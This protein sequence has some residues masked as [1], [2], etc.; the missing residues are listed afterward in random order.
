MISRTIEFRGLLSFLCLIFGV[1]NALGDEMDMNTIFKELQSAALLEPFYEM[2][3]MEPPPSGEYILENVTVNGEINYKHYAG[4][5]AGGAIVE[6]ADGR[7]M[8]IGSEGQA[9]I[10]GNDIRST[11]SLALT[12]YSWQDALRFMSEPDKE[13]ARAAWSTWRDEWGMPSEPEDK[14]VSKAILSLLKLT[15]PTDSF[16][17]LHD[18][19][20]TTKGY[21]VESPDG[22]FEMYR[23]N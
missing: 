8:F 2:T 1:A 10:I 16:G 5:G 15:E 20:S 7:V 12:L 17:S 22:E 14:A 9:G 13:K 11:L 3:S 18:A 23:A 21:R 4:D 6:L 19:V